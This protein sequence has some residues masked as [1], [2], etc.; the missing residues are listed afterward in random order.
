MTDQYF[1]TR[2]E[3]KAWVYRMNIYL[4]TIRKDLTVDVAGDV[5]ISDKNL[6]YIPVQFGEVV[7]NFYCNRNK[8]IN[9]KGSPR[10]C[11]G[12]FWCEENQLTS[13]KYAPE[14]C[15]GGFDCSHNQLTSLDGSPAECHSYFDCSNNQ[16][17]DLKGSPR[18]CGG[19]FD[20]SHNHI[21]AL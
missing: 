6:A 16:L 3:T 10:V 4:Y 2:E 5:D 8:L 21:H 13:L 11:D 15:G 14:K 19:G 17:T 7:G 9:L 18:K 12:N 20:C 1:K